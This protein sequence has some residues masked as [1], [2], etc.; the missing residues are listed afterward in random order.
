[1]SCGHANFR[2]LA[3]RKSAALAIGDDPYLVKQVPQHA[4]SLVT[5]QVARL[6]IF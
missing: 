5:K 2:D 1:V 4:L 6:L 3:E